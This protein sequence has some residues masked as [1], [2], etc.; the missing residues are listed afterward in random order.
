[1]GLSYSSIPTVPQYF[2][3]WIYVGAPLRNLAFLLASNDGGRPLAMWTA[4]SVSVHPDA[5][6]GVSRSVC[7]RHLILSCTR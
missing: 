1:M 3:R 4:R 6:F 5:E 2:D 7:L